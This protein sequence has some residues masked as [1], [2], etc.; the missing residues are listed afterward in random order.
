MKCKL[1]HLLT[2]PIWSSQ[3]SPAIWWSSSCSLNHS[4]FFPVP[5]YHPCML[6]FSLSEVGFPLLPCLSCHSLCGLFLLCKGCSVICQFFFKKN[7]SLDKCI[8]GVSIEGMSSGSSYNPRNTHLGFV[9]AHL[10]F[11][12]FLFLSEQLLHNAQVVD[13]YSR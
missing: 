3:F 6:Q 4:F 9:D 8:F 11:H 2:P 5:L 10:G 7:F 12:S 1:G 13:S